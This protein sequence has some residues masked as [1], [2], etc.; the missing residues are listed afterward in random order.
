MQFK[1]EEISEFL[2]EASKKEE[3]RVNRFNYLR[4]DFLYCATQKDYDLNEYRKIRIMRLWYV[5]VFMKLGLL[6]DA[7]EEKDG[8]YKISHSDYNKKYLSSPYLCEKDNSV[9]LLPIFENKMLEEWS[10][11]LGQT[12]ERKP[13]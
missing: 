8:V 1:E 7:I 11:K 13:E 9:D 5:A 2:F 12:L 3:E 4:K 6:P 10:K